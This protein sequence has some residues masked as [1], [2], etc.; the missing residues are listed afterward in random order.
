MCSGTDGSVLFI[1][2]IAPSIGRADL[3]ELFR[4]TEGFVRLHL[5]EPNRNRNWHRLGWVH[6]T[7]PEHG[8]QA[9]QKM[10]GYKVRAHA[11]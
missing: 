10:N 9:L 1:R 11:H 6:Y 4:A 7:D 5:S 3:L 8:R 2:T